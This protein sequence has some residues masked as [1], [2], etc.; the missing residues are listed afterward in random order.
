MDISY[1]IENADGK[2]RFNY[3]VAGIV[4]QGDRFL[5]HQF[6]GADF[7][8]LVGGRVKLGETAEQALLREFEEELGVR[9][10][11]CTVA[12]VAENFFTYEA[13]A[14]HELS[15]YFNVEGL[16]PEALPL[17]GETREN[18]TFLWR[19]RDELKTLNLQP[20]FLKAELGKP[21]AGIRHL[22]HLD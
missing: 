18:I 5:I 7:F 15:F 6:K 3:R 16:S 9:P 17:D 12:F 4:T 2:Q 8:F 11:S 10:L 13:E 19:T 22:V 1:K 14:F 20:E 21:L